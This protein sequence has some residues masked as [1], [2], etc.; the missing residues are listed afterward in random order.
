[1]AKHTITKDLTP[2]QETVWEAVLALTNA[3]RWAD[4]QLPDVDALISQ[5]FDELTAGAEAF[6]RAPI[7][8][9]VTAKIDTAT[10]AEIDAIDTAAGTKPK[11]VTTAD[12]AATAME[13][14]P[15]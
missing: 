11:A 10:L 4:Q 5:R 14:T 3:S 1:M 13:A 8:E 9:R 6:V 2:D 15:R 12:V 7:K